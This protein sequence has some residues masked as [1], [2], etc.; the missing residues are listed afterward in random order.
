MGFSTNL[1]ILGA[2]AA[3]LFAACQAAEAGL[4]LVLMER[5]HRPGLKLLMCGNNRCNFGHAGTPEELL[6]A[7]GEP[8][9][10]FLR[11]AVRALPS[12]EVA[13][14]LERRGLP[15]KRLGDRF[16]PAS[17]RGDDLLHLLTDLLRRQQVPILYQCPARRI[18]PLPEG[19][20]QVDAPQ[21]TLTCRHLLLAVGGCSYPQT[22]SLGDGLLFA[23]DLGLAS[24]PPRAGLA[25][26]RLP[27]EDPLANLGREEV[28]IP[29]VKARARGVEETEGNLQL[30]QGLLRGSA[31]YDMTRKLARKALPLREATLD[32]LP[33]YS[34][35]E[36]EARREQL[37]RRHGAD[38]ELVLNGLGL[39]RT[40]A[41]SLARCRKI[42]WNALKNYPLDKAAVRP[43]KEA[44]VT[45]GGI[46]LEEFDPRTMECR[47]YPGLYGAGECLDVD[48]PT[49]GYNLE[50][51]FATAALAVRSILAHRP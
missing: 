1:L 28:E 45:V 9:A 46:A 13:R 21:V 40:L 19:G 2:G 11:H 50:A 25:A 36:L 49:G 32:L 12:T 29:W 35:E 10:G 51:A 38:D 34:Q 6:R 31:V 44:I 20:F 30:Q 43:L 23:Q 14:F 33:K 47:K 4:P 42:P 17:E 26:L 15:V 48:G 41:A 22:G 39:P 5:R 16:Y 18:T 27:P 3:G 37:R 7:Y 8:V 24:S